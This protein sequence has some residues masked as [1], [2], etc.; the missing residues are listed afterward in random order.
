MVQGTNGHASTTERP[1]TTI[2]SFD[3]CGGLGSPCRVVIIFLVQLVLFL[4]LFSFDNRIRLWDDR[5]QEVE[6]IGL[7][8][9][10]ILSWR[11]NNGDMPMNDKY[12]KGTQQIECLWVGTDNEHKGDSH[13]DYFKDRRHGNGNG[14]VSGFR[15]S[16]SSN[17]ARSVG[18]PVGK[19]QDVQIHSIKDWFS[20]ISQHM[21]RA[22][23]PIGSKIRASY[24]FG[25]F[26]QTMTNRFGS[27]LELAWPQI[28]P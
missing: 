25:S 6:S 24:F 4:F 19:D 11:A 21:K 1:W 26:K 12:R 20:W 8:P 3:C 10:R 22:A 7:D 14:N 18:L 27:V 13:H 2:S 5:E 9:L 15:N 23:L 17:L 28:L 16:E